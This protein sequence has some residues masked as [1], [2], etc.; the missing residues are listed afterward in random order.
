[1]EAAEGPDFLEAMRKARI[2]GALVG[3]E[4]VTAEGLK[5]VDKD[6]NLSGKRPV[7]RLR[8]FQEHGVHVLGAFIF[9]LRPYRPDIPFKQPKNWHSIPA[10]P[11]P[12]L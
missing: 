1:M 12:N 7:Q 5:A 11:L 3:I 10:L 2:M 8:Q 4:A 9:G 6:F